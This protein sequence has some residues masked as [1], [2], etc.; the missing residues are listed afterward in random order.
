MSAILKE[1]K[2]TSLICG[3]ILAFIFCLALYIRA[4]IPYNIVFTDHFVRFAVYD[5]WYNLRLLENTLHHFPYRIYFDPFTAYPFGTYNPFGAPFFDMSLAFI[6]RVIEPSSSALGL[7]ELEVIAAFYP[8]VLGTLT[9]LPVYYIGKALYNRGTGLMSAALIAIIPGQFLART[10][11]GYT[12]HHAMETLLSTI[13]ILFF[14]LALKSARENDITFYS[15]T[16]RDWQSLKM[17]FVYSSLA[18][19]SIGLYFLTW[20][21]APLIVFILLVYA[22]VQYTIDHLRDTSTDYLCILSMPVFIIP[23]VMIAPALTHG[24]L[25]T[26]HPISLLMGI[27][28]FLAFAILSFLFSARE[29]NPY[30]YPVTILGFGVIALLLLRVLNPVL[31]ATLTGPFMYIFAPS[32][33]DLAI[34]EVQ[35]MSWDNILNWFYTTF[36]IA[37]AGLAWMVYNIAKKFRSEEVFFVVWSIVILLACFGQ[38]RFAAYYAVNVAILCGFVAWQ[39]IEFVDLREEQERNRAREKIKKDKGK[40]TKTKKTQEPEKKLLH[41]DACIAFAVIVLVL[42]FPLIGIPGTKYE[43]RTIATAKSESGPQYDWYESL[44]WMRDNT[45][46]T[47]VDYYA[48]YA[49]PETRNGYEYP[50][51]AYS[52][53]NWWDYGHWITRIA[54]RI[55]VANNFQQG[56]GGPYRDNLP[57]ACVFFTATNETEA[58]EV[59][60]A[61]DVRYVVSDYKMVDF[62]DSLYNKFSAMMLWAG[63]TEGYYAQVKTKEGDRV[64]RTTKFYKTLE[65]RLHLFDGTRTVIKTEVI[66]ALQHYRLVHESP[67]YLIPFAVEDA[68]SGD[69]RRWEHYEGDYQSAKTEAENLHHGVEMEGGQIKLTP[70]FIKPVSFVK[71][72][73]YVKGAQIVG[74]APNGSLVLITANVAT[75]QGREFAYSQTTVSNGTYTF[76]VPYSTGGPID[77]ETDFDVFAETYKIHE[78]HIE[79]ETLVWETPKAVAVSEEAVLAG[80]TL[81]ID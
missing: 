6:I 14:I 40:K 39:I 71:V 44:S 49:V 41:T 38:N 51:S 66:P 37:L 45:P 32:E 79:D 12:D 27:T 56:I 64:K 30:W 67:Q 3:A 16:D 29:V 35:P 42:F 73:E 15:F 63:D 8:V 68:R 10:L 50:E 2:R 69:I 60:D 48:L 78:G 77:G 43:G 22:L 47:G 55:P 25:Q 52:V 18:G 62:W 17:P 59:A 70:E 4:A 81:K 53:M 7:H 28:V 21:G 33:I 19:F 26:F 54:H 80:K 24:F 76:I 1:S 20:M 31:F 34:A 75:N 13:A 61:L 57:G 74:T 9:I 58:N 5:P 72:F 11:L 36:F 46:D 65:A 23:L